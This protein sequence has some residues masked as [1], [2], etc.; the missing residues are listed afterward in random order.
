MTGMAAALLLVIGV[1]LASRPRQRVGRPR[2]AAGRVSQERPAGRWVLVGLV[3]MAA[4]ASLVGIPVASVATA[5]GVAVVVLSERS[6]ARR[7]RERL[8]TA[9]ACEEYA[10]LL[11]AEL[12]AGQT[13]AAA[14][15]AAS[16]AGAP[17]SSTA[18]RVA[19]L[20]G[21]PVPAL[22]GGA[23]DPGAGSLRQ[24]AA[25]WQVSVTTGAPLAAV[26]RRTSA[27]VRDDLLTLH[28][29]QE[30]LA[31]VRAT[32]RVLAGLPLMGVVVGAGFGVNVPNLLLTTT[33]GQLC[34]LAAVVLVGL[35][36][37]AIDWIGERVGRLG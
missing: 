4:V 13:P 23:C 22:L 8:A 17:G 29:V 1:S 2:A 24:V 28:E 19:A 16:T 27:A 10:M 21:D 15:A 30:Q 34:L 12:S 33:W 35:G 37:W 11:A 6:R 3:A 9:A 18:A 20:G 7:R 5:L 31:P 26:L 25:A 32:G 36:L 14:L